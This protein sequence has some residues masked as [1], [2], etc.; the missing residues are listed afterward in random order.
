VFNHTQFQAVASSTG[1]FN[2]P[3]F[4]QASAAADARIGQLALK[5]QF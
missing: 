2:S 4:G 1:N 5:L 3:E